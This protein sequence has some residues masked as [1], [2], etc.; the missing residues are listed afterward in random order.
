[1]APLIYQTLCNVRDKVGSMPV[2]DL[3]NRGIS[4][5]SDNPAFNVEYFEIVDKNTLM[6][7]ENRTN[8]QNIILVT[9]V[10]LGD[11]R[12]IDNLELF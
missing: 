1:M 3:Q 4:T 11:I 8:M 2:A 6:P 9:A 10:Y 12:L 5:I 7:V